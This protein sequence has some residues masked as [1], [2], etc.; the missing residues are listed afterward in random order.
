MVTEQNAVDYICRT[1]GTQYPASARP[2]E[3]CPICEDERQYVGLK[4]QQ[5]TTL[6]ALQ[7]DYHCVY[8][9][10]DLHA[11]TGEF[12]DPALH[13]SRTREMAIGLLASGIDPERNHGSRM[14]RQRGPSLSPKPR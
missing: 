2:P 14:S 12:Y 3:H 4:G 10:V 13:A 5:W 8:C 11:I 9:I 7:E 6:S 1:C